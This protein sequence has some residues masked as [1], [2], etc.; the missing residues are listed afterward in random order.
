M[1]KYANNSQRFLAYVIDFS[2]IGLMVSMLSSAVFKVMNFDLA[3]NDLMLEKIMSEL[4]VALE[5]G[6]Y[7]DFYNYYMDFLKYSMVEIGVQTAVAFVVFIGY[8]VVLPCFWSKQTVGR[9][10]SKTKVIMLDGTK[11]TKKAIIIRELV[12]SFLLYYCV[13]AIPLIITWVFLNKYQRSLVDRISDTVLIYDGEVL[14]VNVYNDVKEDATND[15]ID[16]KF[17]DVEETKTAKN[18]KDEPEADDDGYIIF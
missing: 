6:Y 4:T 12:G 5:T 8:L 18:K 9:M 15:Y 10:I 14:M 3:I 7:T 1:K 16:A 13:G 17:V 11:A 2:L